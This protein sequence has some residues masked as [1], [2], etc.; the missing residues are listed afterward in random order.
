M[1]NAVLV[2]PEVADGEK[3]LTALAGAGIVPTVALWAKTSEY[4]LP[5]LFVA[6]PEFEGISNLEAHGIIAD[7][8]QPVFTWSAPNFVVLRMKDKFISA[9]RAAFGQAGSV[10]G[11]RLG[12]QLFGD[13]YIEDAYVYQI[14]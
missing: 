2:G 10:Y 5:R 4:D 6:S 7:A 1:A 11:M 8:V 9:L 14:R 12:G 3:A 13:R